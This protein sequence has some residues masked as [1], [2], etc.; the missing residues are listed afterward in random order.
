MYQQSYDDRVCAQRIQPYKEAVGTGSTGSKIAPSV[1]CGQGLRPVM[2]SAPASC[3]LAPHCRCS[4][5][6]CQTPMLR[7]HL[8]PE[9]RAVQGRHH[10]S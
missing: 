8:A 10:D 5:P 4:T 1:D 7:A 2:R 6:T 3:C 9:L